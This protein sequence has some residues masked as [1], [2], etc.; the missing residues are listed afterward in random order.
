YCVGERIEDRNSNKH[1][2]V[3]RRQ[4]EEALADIS[5]GS[6]NLIIAYEPVW[7][8]GTGINATPEQAEEMHSF[9]RSLFFN[10]RD[11]TTSE[12]IRI[13]Y[14]GS[15]KPDNIDSLMRMDNIDGV[16]VGGASIKADQFIRII[17]YRI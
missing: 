1:F 7:A 4:I 12:D 16:L 11:K 17:D 15:V 5:F 8:I 3:V 9:I 10:I 13:L 14:G 6:N 2:D